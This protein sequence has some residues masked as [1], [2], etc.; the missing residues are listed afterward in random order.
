MS[1]FERRSSA[2]GRRLR[3][4]NARYETTSDSS[5][6]GKHLRSRRTRSR[7]PRMA[8]TVTD[9]DVILTNSAQK[10]LSKKV[11]MMRAKLAKFFKRRIKKQSSSDDG[12]TTE[13]DHEVYIPTF[14]SDEEFREF[15]R[16]LDE[17]RSYAGNRKLCAPDLL[18][19]LPSSKT[20]EAIH[21]SRSD[22]DDGR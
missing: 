12:V 20:P 17:N 22:L 18:S 8:I 15:S 10:V 3:R 7:N 11:D 5:E 2:S 9:G 13:L 6:E 4:Y 21:D 14:M 16:K 1:S 19:D